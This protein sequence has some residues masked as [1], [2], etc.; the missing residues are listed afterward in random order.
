[1][2]AEET[3]NLFVDRY[4]RQHK[5]PRTAVSD[6]DPRFVSDFWKPFMQAIGSTLRMSSAAHPETDG[7]AEKVNDV[8]GTYLRCFA[9][10]FYRDWH[11]LLALAEYT[12]NATPQKSLRKVPFEV[13]LG[14]VPS[15]KLSLIGA[16]LQPQLSQASAQAK[17]G[18]DFA[19][20][21]RSLLSA[22]RDDLEVARDSQRASANAHWRDHKDF[23]HEGDLV[24]VDVPKDHMTYS[25]VVSASS[26][27]Q[28]R[29]GGPC[30]V[31]WVQGTAVKLDMGKDLPVHPAFHVSRIRLDTT[32]VTRDQEPSPPLRLAK[33]GDTM[34]E[35]HEVVRIRDHAA[36]GTN[37]KHLQ[38]L[39]EWKGTPESWQPLDSMRKRER[40]V[41]EEYHL[42]RGL[43]PVDWDAQHREK[44]LRVRKKRKEFW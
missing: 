3:A 19:V 30:R 18:S 34:E 10:R 23:V 42:E 9:T 32:D 38:Y 2:G 36:A 7:M 25:N 11:T 6:R 24:L 13:D 39:V 27:L 29:Y 12:Y 4:F 33:R 8:V 15:S 40:E 37:K 5:V 21:L 14:Y 16:A 20:H 1:M 26:K 43:G 28:H 17:A 41:M 44:Q 22:A 35:V 31:I